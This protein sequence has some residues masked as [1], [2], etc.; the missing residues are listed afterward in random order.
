[1]VEQ[2]PSKQFCT[3]HFNGSETCKECR[4]TEVLELTATCTA[5]QWVTTATKTGGPESCKAPAY[6][7]PAN[8]GIGFLHDTKR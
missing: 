8:C 7:G 3:T 5:G 6:I 1:M 4:W 2:Q